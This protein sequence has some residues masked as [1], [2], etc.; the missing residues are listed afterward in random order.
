MDIPVGT[1]Y[2]NTKHGHCT[3]QLVESEFINQAVYYESERLPWSCSKVACSVCG[4]YNNHRH[5]CNGT[6]CQAER[7]EDGKDVYWKL[8]SVGKRVKTPVTNENIAK[9]IPAWKTAL[10]YKKGVHDEHPCINCE[11]YINRTCIKDCQAKEAYDKKY[12]EEI[13]HQ[14]YCTNRSYYEEHKNE[15]DRYKVN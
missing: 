6:C 3:F 9:Y 15:H 11:Q 7:R 1:I 12:A 5:F 10:Y 13:W 4:C 8:I 14:R 2:T